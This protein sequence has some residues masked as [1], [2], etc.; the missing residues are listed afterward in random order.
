MNRRIRLTVFLLM[1]TSVC[2]GSKLSG[3]V[4]SDN[5]KMITSRYMGYV[6]NM[7]VAEG[8]IV[9]RPATCMR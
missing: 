8:D 7:A 5:Q 9:Q 4:V 6:R 1:M 3:S 2:N